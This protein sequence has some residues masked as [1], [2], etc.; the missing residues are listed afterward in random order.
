MQLDEGLANGGVDRI[1]VGIADQE[2][3]QYDQFVT[4][5]VTNFLIPD[6]GANRYY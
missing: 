6:F 4:E 5:E 1:L 3:Q 2:S